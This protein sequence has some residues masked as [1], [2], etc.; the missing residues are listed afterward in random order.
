[1]RRRDATRA[2]VG[3]WAVPGAVAALLV[4][5]GLASVAA[6][7]AL[8][9]TVG[10]GAP[11][12]V[13]AAVR[14]DLTAEDLAR[15]AKVTAPATSFTAAETSEAM[16]GGAATSTAAADRN[17]FSHP[18]ANLSFAER[19]TFALGNGIFRKIWVS[20][21][22][23]TAASDGLGPLYNARGCQA[24]HLKDGRGA[25]PA[26]GNTG[27]SMFLRL[28]VPPATPD[29]AAQLAA[30]EKT[31][32]PEPNYGGQLQHFAVPGLPAE[33]RMTLAYTEE[34]VTLSGGETASL[35]RP[36]Y[37]VEALAYG[38]L[39]PGTM[40]S[41]RVAAPMIGLG[42]L[43]AVHPS[44]IG[45][46]ADPDDRDDDG[47][48]GRLSL[49]R[50]PR[51][52][53]L[54]V[55]R[56][57]WKASAPSIE[58]QSAEAFSGDMGISTPLVT[59]AF[60]ECSIA[61]QVCRDAPDGVQAR[62]GEVEAPDP[63]LS[64]VTFYS[65]NLAVPARRD[66]G[67]R[68]VLRGKKAF[69]DAGCASCHQPKFVTSRTAAGQAQRFQLIWPYSDLLLHDMGEGLADHA[70]VGSASGTEWRTQPLWGVGLTD[71]VNGHTQLLHD[72][73]ARN[74]LEAILWHG[75][76]AAAAREAVVAMPPEERAALLAFVGSL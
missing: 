52:G 76:E 21:P 62:L 67:D 54:A 12:L 65:R 43:E 11:D 68:T 7:V 64:L 44:D 40:L 20:S 53:A 50:E 4:P 45:A 28:S 46:L 15:V 17:A 74:V 10:G 70:P 27:V 57:G 18:S 69:Y 31:R 72:G 19:E 61:Q 63:V 16:P 56:F 59:D 24:C 3:G 35:R 29:E 42:L 8:A 41:P 37:G 2:A 32:I 6:H 58:A 51:S 14:D 47:I 22:A 49:T 34:V 1:M 25:P 5:L 60:G 66:F 36:T 23:S 9:A 75:G 48:S 71:A 39:A 26:P 13:I 33:G 30:I 73:R 38:P 55:G